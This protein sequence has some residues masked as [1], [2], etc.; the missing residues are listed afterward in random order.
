[1]SV[2]NA[3]KS[4]HS[5]PGTPLIYTQQSTP[6]N[7][8]HFH[9]C[10]R[11][12][13]AQTPTIP[14]SPKKAPHYVSHRTSRSNHSPR[15]VRN[16]R[17]THRRGA[18]VPEPSWRAIPVRAFETAPLAGNPGAEATPLEQPCERG[19]RTH[20]R[21]DSALLLFLATVHG[22]K[23]GTGRA[24]DPSCRVRVHPVRHGPTRRPRSSVALPY[25]Y[26]LSAILGYYSVSTGAV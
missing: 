25:Q 8:P 1:M 5:Q 2:W 22:Q 13:G 11:V 3:K 23:V 9:L 18:G 24:S 12:S 20:Y 7:R 21:S 19:P 26:P 6:T 16:T 15:P 4:K 17:Q 14:T 10:K